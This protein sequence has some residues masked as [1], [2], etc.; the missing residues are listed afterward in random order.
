MTAL[1]S[2]N[3]GEGTVTQRLGGGRGGRWMCWCWKE[4]DICAASFATMILLFGNFETTGSTS[5]RR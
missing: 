1:V 4:N 2:R 5:E 3:E